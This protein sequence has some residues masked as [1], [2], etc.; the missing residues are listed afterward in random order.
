MRIESGPTTERKIRNTLLTIMVSVFA[1]WFAYDGWVGYPAKNHEE[2]LGQLA[3][4]ERDKARTGPVYSKLRFREAGAHDYWS[5]EINRIIS[6]NS[7]AES[8]KAVEA[9][10]GGPPSYENADAWYYFGPAYQLKIPLIAGAPDKVVA[11]RGQKKEMDI[12]TQKALAIGLACLSAYLIWFVLRVARTRLVLDD[13][14]LIYRG[15]GPIRW[16]DMKALDISAFARKGYTFLVYDDHG[17]QRRLK[18]DEYHLARFDEV[19]DEICARKG[20][21][22]PLP[23]SDG[24]PAEPANPA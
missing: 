4:T 8:K 18:L 22:N 10:I 2:F 21:E 16:E 5:G 14:G 1:T 15:L 23:V 11:S 9:R 20:F 3:T 13:S 6:Q 7:I 19:I 24:A 12:L 17:S